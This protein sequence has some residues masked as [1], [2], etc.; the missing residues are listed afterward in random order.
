MTDVTDVQAT[1][2]VDTSKENLVKEDTKEPAT[3]KTKFSVGEVAEYKGV[4]VSVLNYEE[5][6]GN[7][8]GAPDEGNIFVFVNIEIT[9]NSDKEISVSS[10]LSFD[11]YCD[12]Y[13]LDFSS[14]ALLAASTANKQQVDG[15]IASGKKLN[16]YLGF[17]VPTDWTTIE[18]NYKD[19][20]WLSSNFSF[21]VTK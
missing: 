9:N 15:S 3:E 13:K 1:E 17:E 14:N 6:T 19:N 18:I 7:D 2:N 5:S 8:W 10:M 20:A 4:Q 21:I 16:G 11:A 12:D